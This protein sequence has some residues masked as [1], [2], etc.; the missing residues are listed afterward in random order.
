[1]IGPRHGEC[2]QLIR[3]VFIR[4]RDDSWDRISIPFGAVHDDTGLRLFVMSRLLASW[5]R[6]A[7]GSFM[8][9]HEGHP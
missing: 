7:P 1:M 2:I 5:V 8:P 6:T 3:P 4:A 9:V